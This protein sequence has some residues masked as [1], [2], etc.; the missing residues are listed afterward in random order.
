MVSL[1]LEERKGLLLMAECAPHGSAADAEPRR[2]DSLRPV[3]GLREGL[4]A[5]DASV[6]LRA[7]MLILVDDSR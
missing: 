7:L 4:W 2:E 3:V 1:L 5:G 6:L